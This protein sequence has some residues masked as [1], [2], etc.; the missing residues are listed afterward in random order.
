MKQM[1]WMTMAALLIF[2]PSSWI[3]AMEEEHSGHGRGSMDHSGHSGKLIREA[4][5]DGYALAYHLI[6]MREKMKDMKGMPEVSN[7]HHLMLYIMAPNGHPVGDA[8]V[9]YLLQGPTGEKQKAMAMG[10][11]EGYGADV[12]LDKMGAY[13]IKTKIVIGDKKM[14]EQFEHHVHSQ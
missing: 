10:M 13:M 12:N 4:T 3:S 11:G 2:F 6:D 9:G 14:M 7:T 5:V 1:L 8:K